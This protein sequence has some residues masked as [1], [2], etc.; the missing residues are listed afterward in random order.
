[1]EKDLAKSKPLLARVV[2]EHKSSYVLRTEKTEL[3]ATI[4]GTFHLTVDFPKVGDFVEYVELTAGQA[5]IE[6]ILPR[7]SVIIRNASERS[8][9]PAIQKPQVIATNVDIM[10]IVMGLDG[11]F[12]VR[13]LERYILLAKQSKITP[14]IILNKVDTVTDL[15]IYTS[16]LS[17][18]SDQASLHFVSAQTGEG[19]GVF[20]P[21]LKPETTA[22]LLGSSGAGKSTI[23][24]WLLGAP[25]Q[26]TSG[27]RQNDS[28]GKHTTTARQLF[29]LPSGGFLIDTPG[30]RELGVIFVEENEKD[31]FT[32]ILTLSQECQY[33][34]CDHEKSEGCAIQAAILT[35]QVDTQKF[36]SYKKLQQEQR[37]HESKDVPQI[38][39]EQRIEKKRRVKKQNRSIE[40]KF[41]NQE[42]LL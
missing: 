2:E 36:Q 28:R 11:D 19:M 16:Q 40:E 31:I 7:K 30:I 34:D 23:T 21:Y 6:R 10:F 24:N 3:T 13:R 37:Y 42:D 12:N 8:R 25:V 4:R 41:L 20:L 35:G 29:S 17:Y 5:V 14:V 38:T 33:T 1:M 15:G 18:L 22:V 26:V 9:N 27:V 39:Q 32:E